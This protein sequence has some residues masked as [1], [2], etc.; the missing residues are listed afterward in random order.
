MPRS[1]R[2]RSRGGGGRIRVHERT[3][4]DEAELIGG[5]IELSAE[6]RNDIVET[7]QMDMADKTRR[8]YRNRI[9]R[10]YMW[11]RNSTDYTGYFEQGTR[12]VTQAKK[13]DPVKF[14]HTN[15]RD[16]IYN[17]LNV[18]VIKAFLSEVKKKKVDD[19]GNILTLSSVS[20]LKKYDDAIKW[21]SRIAGEPLPSSYYRDIDAF[22]QAYKKE[23]KAAAKEGK[24]DTQEADPIT[25]ALFRLICQ[26]AVEEGNMYVWVFSLAMWNL[27]S[28]SIS[29]G[30]LSLHNIKSG[31]SDSIKFKYDET[32]ADKTG[33]FVQEKN[34]YANPV[35]ANLCFFLSLGVWISVGAERLE[36]TEKLFIMPGSK[37]GSAS[38]R[39]CTQLSELV[40]RHYKQAKHHLRVSH[41]NAHGIRKGSGSHAS[42][43]TTSPPSFVSVAARG[44]W[45]MGK[46]LDV[47][48]RF[49][50]GGDQ[51]LGRILSLLDPAKD[52]FAMLP[53]HWKDPTHPTVLLGIKIAFRDVLAEHEET[54]HDPTGLLSL[55]LASMVH[56]STWLLEMCSE[57]PDHPF[58][59]IPILNHEI[60]SVLKNE[61]LTLEP[62]PHVPIATGVPPH[63]AHS[64]DIKEVKVLCTETKD[65][66]TDFRADLKASVSDAVDAK[67]RAEGGV[68]Q[69]VLQ[70]SLDGL[71]EELFERLE[72]LAFQSSNTAPALEGIAS[73]IDPVARFA[74]P[75]EFKYRGSSWPVPESFQFA[76][77]LT[78]L[79][80]WRQWLLG[81]VHFDGGQLW[82]LKPHRKFSGRDLHSKALQDVYRSEWK[83]IFGAMMEAPG[84]HIPRRDDIGENFVQSSYTIATDHLKSRFSYIFRK[85]AGIVSS[86]TIGTWSHKIK[87]HVVRKYGTES[88]LARLPPATPRNN[89]HR[90]KR[91]FTHQRRRQ[92]RK[93][94]RAG[95][96]KRATMALV[97][98]DEEEG[99]GKREEE[100]NL[101]TSS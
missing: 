44:E 73:S 97:E 88:D 16:L 83:P 67:V 2:G 56:H 69:S 60:L 99:D 13:E 65:A 23:Y 6:H 55:L 66:V 25:V 36:G 74:G 85:S 9:K 76:S 79:N 18:M 29:V 72:S 45:S 100:A 78:R 71:K 89:P 101:R 28:R 91:T 3:V 52:T 51:Y 98:S 31:C 43:A 48:F 1:R 81:S 62:S 77:G 40:V 20:D 7:E 93:V 80:G 42:S 27:M 30:Q 59:A 49:A 84:L 15:D 64:R 61:H 63:V 14:H 54:N 53:P 17:G 47:Y 94:A 46:I 19:D 95:A 24:T 34:C 58:H 22:I 75:F 92:V 8:E 68:N 11:L 32:K 57:H 87:P 35:E 41:F 12:L 5:A 26:W 37:A 33:E 96:G 86:Y 4:D 21:G 70:N 39:Y 90:T 10:I 50:M 38:Q 82:R